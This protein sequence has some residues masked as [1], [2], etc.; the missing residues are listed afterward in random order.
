MERVDS[1]S[2]WDDIV[3]IIMNRKLLEAIIVNR[4]FGGHM[5]SRVV[6][7]LVLMVMG[8]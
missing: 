2:S 8:S 5:D 7:S 1:N 3:T 6:M 4:G